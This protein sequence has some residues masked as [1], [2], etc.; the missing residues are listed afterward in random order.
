[1]YSLG[2]RAAA[3][4]TRSLVVFWAANAGLLDGSL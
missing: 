1:M 2:G 4:Q 3:L